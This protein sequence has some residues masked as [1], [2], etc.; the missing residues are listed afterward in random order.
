MMPAME[1]SNPVPPPPARVGDRLDD[2]E[3]PALVVDLDAFERNLARM[4]AF[5]AGAGIG[6]RA[7]AKTHRSSEVARRQVAAGAIGQ[8]VQTV[9]EAEALVA[10]GIRDVLVSNEVVGERKLG[11]L[12][13][14]GHQATIALCFDSPEMVAAASR[15]A[16]AAGTE[17]G[18]L[19]EIEVGM[20]RCG[21][22][23][24]PEAAALA[25]RIVDAPGL[26]FVGLQAYHGRAQHLASAAERRAA[27]DGAVMAVRETRAAL[28]D[29]GLPCPVV[30]GAGTGT[31]RLEAASGIYTELQAGSYLFMDGEY[32]SIRDED[33]RPYREFE[34]SLFVLSRVMSV[35]GREI[36]RAHV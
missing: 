26:R 30:G 33:D 19:V 34:H 12:A 24:G 15:A 3:T 11:R 36:G 2:V 32:A 31:F 5:A 1:H 21:V 25:R 28:A 6:L 4:A 23:P 9:G 7:H 22:A 18:G 13:A 8:C 20:G 10:G 29:A 27:I 16:V 17:L 14:L 35:A